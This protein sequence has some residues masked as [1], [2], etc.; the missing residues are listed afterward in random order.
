MIFSLISRGVNYMTEVKQVLPLIV[1]NNSNLLIES[2]VFYLME[3]WD[4]DDYRRLK[5]GYCEMS[6]INLA[7]AELGLIEDMSDLDMYVE[8]LGREI[9]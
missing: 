1:N 8:R 4:Y 2:L 7:L 9:S 3:E 5:S 6:Q